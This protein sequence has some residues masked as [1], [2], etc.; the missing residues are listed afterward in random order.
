MNVTVIHMAVTSTA[1]TPLVHIGAAVIVV[2]F[3]KKI[4]DVALVC[5]IACYHYSLTL[6]V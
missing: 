6:C 2:M 3:L 5:Y 4:D 1:T